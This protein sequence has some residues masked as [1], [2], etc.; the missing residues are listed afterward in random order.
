M[1]IEAFPEIENFQH[2]PRRVIVKGGDS[3]F[4]QDEGAR[5]RG[6]VIN[7]IGQTIR[8]LKVSVVIFNEKKIPVLNTSIV[9]DPSAIPQGGISSFSFHLKEYPQQISD[10][11]LY[12]DWTF[13]DKE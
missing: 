1:G 4:S 10:Y 7:N 13:D 2:L 5:L 11:Y 6:I 9:P 12:T 8:N 3:S